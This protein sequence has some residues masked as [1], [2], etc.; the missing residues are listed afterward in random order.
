MVAT[1]LVL[2][3]RLSDDFGIVI[4][5]VRFVRYQSMQRLVLAAV[6]VVA[7]AGEHGFGANYAKQS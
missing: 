5:L 7:V 2:I 4:E 6:V 1:N 3:S